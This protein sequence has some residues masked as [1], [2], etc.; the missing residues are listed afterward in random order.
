MDAYEATRIVLSRIQ[1]LDPENAS[2]I[3]S[4]LLIQ[5]HG[6][7]EMIRLAF[8]PEALLHSVVLKA[9]KDLGLLPS[10]TPST[11][12]PSPF[13][14]S[15][16]N[17]SSRLPSPSSWALP[18][19]FSRRNGAVD[20]LQSSDDPVSP[21]SSSPSPFLGSDLVDEFHLQ[22]QFSFLNDPLQIGAQKVHGEVFYPENSESVLFNYAGM[23]WNLHRRSLS[24]SENR[25]LSPD[26]G[27]DLG[28]RPCLYFAR[29]FC[30]NGSSCRFLH[31]LPDDAMDQQFQELLLR[32][33]S[34][35]LLAAAS[36]FPYS[37]S[38]PSPSSGKCVNFLQQPQS[39][40]QRSSLNFFSLTSSCSNSRSSSSRIAAAV[41]ALSLGGEEQLKFGRS[42]LE[43]VGDYSGTVNP[44]SRQ[45]YLTFPADSTFREEDVAN[46][47]R[48]GIAYLSL[49][50]TCKKVQI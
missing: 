43:R 44:G 14:L 36:S 38:P 23:N 37:H 28:W 21:N 22:D 10:S 5:D 42:R 9:R 45:I 24:A 18:H 34:P 40:T 33:K 39:E 47:F 12:S 17:S 25:C 6:E 8:G 50:L 1:T 16:Q 7:K 15:R 46:Y 30:K 19:P 3:M 49:S 48:F 11:P 29:G 32:T 41:A 27:A 4:L 31:G 2:K 26:A 20:E 35:R 13:L